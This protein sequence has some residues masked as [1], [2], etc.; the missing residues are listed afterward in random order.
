MPAERREGGD[1]WTR[2]LRVLKRI[3]GMPDYAGYL[4]HMAERHPGCGVL[5]ER[6]FF[7]EQVQARYGNGASRCC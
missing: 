7:D 2:A 3:T 1:R 6:Q 5:T 4:E